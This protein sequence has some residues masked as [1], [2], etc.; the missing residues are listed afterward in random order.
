M[1]KT[2]EEWMDCIWVNLELII[3]QNKQNYLK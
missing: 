2:G 1:K 3:E